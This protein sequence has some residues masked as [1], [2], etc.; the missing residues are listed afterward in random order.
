MFSSVHVW[1]D[2]RIYYKEAM[3]LAQY[4]Y[5]VD[6]YA[7]EKDTSSTDTSTTDTSVHVHLLPKKSRWHRPSRGP[8]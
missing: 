4:G 7:I 2:T 6:L 3:T 8:P 1:I 5:H